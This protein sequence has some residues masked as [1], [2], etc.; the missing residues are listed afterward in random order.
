MAI[1]NVKNLHLHYRTRRGPVRAVDGVDFEI[2]RGKVLAL[3]GESG[4]G[5]SS[6]ANAI[7]RVLPRN[8]ARFEGEVQFN[9]SDIMEYDGETFRQKIRWVGISMVFQGAMNSLNPVLRVGYQVA[10]PLL[11]HLDVEK[12]EAIEEAEKALRKVGLPPG[13]VDRYPHELSGGMKQR[14]VIAMALILRPRLLILDEP[15]SALDVM[16]QANIMNLLK[17]LQ[18]QENLSYIFITHDLALASE[19][20]SHVAI[21]YAGQIVEIG[22]AEDIYGNP[23]HPYTQLLLE[24]VPRLVAD[25]T[26]KSIPGTPPD[27]VEPPEGCRFRPRCPYAFEKCTEDPPFFGTERHAACWLLAKQGGG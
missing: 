24:S 13:T 19:L 4:C 10:E 25:V 22:A 3:V 11:Y 14:A 6:T 12:D 27:L 7:L 23:I 8:V 15:T 16:T 21:M 2:E 9:G 5:K 20:A 26:P 1:L 18:K 17:D